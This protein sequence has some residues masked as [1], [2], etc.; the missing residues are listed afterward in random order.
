MSIYETAQ[1]FDEEIIMR[2]MVRALEKRV[3]VLN[4]PEDAD[5][6]R[7]LLAA[8]EALEVRAFVRAF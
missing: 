4:Q 2:Q 6:T 5:E 3:A 1:R 8:I 7:Q